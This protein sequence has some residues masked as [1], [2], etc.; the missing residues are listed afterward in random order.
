MSSS[1]FR[2]SASGL[3]A[4]CMLLLS[5]VALPGCIIYEKFF[6]NPD[7]FSHRPAMVMF[8]NDPDITSDGASVTA[9]VTIEMDKIHIGGLAVKDALSMA[10]DW[11]LNVFTLNGS[12]LDGNDKYNTEEKIILQKLPLDKMLRADLDMHPKR[13]LKGSDAEVGPDAEV[14]TKSFLVLLHKY[15]E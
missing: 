10:R 7:Q 11:R 1:I 2:Q 12:Y 3:M 14:L 9:S 8:V 13:F 4:G 6:G 5:L 15:P